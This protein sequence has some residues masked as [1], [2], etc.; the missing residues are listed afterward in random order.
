MAKKTD[1]TKPTGS[2]PQGPDASFS[3]HEAQFRA[4][5][6]SI[7]DYAIYMLDTEGRIITWNAG[8]ERLK[9]FREE[10]VLGQHFS[11]F[12]PPEEIEQR[13]PQRELELASADGRFEDEG[14]RLRK[15]G[16]FFWANVVITPVRD[17]AGQLLGFAKV[18]RDLTERRQTTQRL[19]ASEARLQAFMN[20]S[21]SLMFI[22]DLA[23]RY[24]YV[25]DP[26]TR[27]FGLERFDIIFRSDAEIFPPGLAAQFAANDSEALAAG[28]GI[29]V[30]EVA[31]YKD[32]ELHTSI[33]HKFPMLDRQGEVVALGGVVT[34]ITER[35]R[36]E[37]E[38]R[39]NNERLRAAIRTEMAL[40]RRQ[41][42]LQRIATQ[43][44]LTGVTNRAPFHRRAELALAGSRRS[45]YVVVLLFID[46]DRFKAINDSLGHSAGDEVLRQVA[47]RLSG[48]LREVD[49]IARQGGDEFIVLLDGIE[50]TEQITQVT[51]RMREEMAKPMAVEGHEVLVTSSI[52]IAV[53]PRD[54]PDVSTLIRMA[55]LAM[56]R[57]K[58]L[59]RNTVQ[60]YT[61]EL[62]TPPKE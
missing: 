57:S 25:N 19:E 52:G 46:I 8:A 23:G 51:T 45:G 9:G 29:E 62:E 42:H 37:E 55:D 27:A 13:L 44:P 58:Q 26:F 41:E 20:H 32:G 5:V 24:L 56:Y 50:N 14:W 54:G 60:F 28:Q 17:P 6:D 11:R 18:T 33:V 43:D 48:C 30:E 12:Y 47:N 4:F 16:S 22:K 59:G 10:E 31:L 61:P 39:Q 38:L 15:D 7:V 21:P 36:L 49:A 35:K 40:R 53:Y 2:I 1:T 3:Q 34:D